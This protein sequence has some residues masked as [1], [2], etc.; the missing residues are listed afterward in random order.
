MEASSSNEQVSSAEPR[1][2]AHSSQPHVGKACPRPGFRSPGDLSY[3]EGLVYHPTKVTVMDYDGH[4][5]TEKELID[6]E[7]CIDLARRPST[8]WVNVTG[9]K[10]LRVIQRLGEI[11]DIHP[12]A[13]EDV[14]NTRHPPK[15]DDYGNS[16]FLIMRK[17]KSGDAGEITTEQVSIVLGENYILTF[18]E[19]ENDPF[20]GVRHRLRQGRFRIRNSGPDYLAYALL[21]AIMDAYFPIL[22]R[23]GER[24]EVLEDQVLR[25]PSQATAVKILDLKREV[26]HLRQLSWAIRELLTHLARMDDLLISKE[27]LVYLR[28]VQ[29]HALR[30]QDQ[31]ESYRE[32]CEGLYQAYVSNLTMRTN[33]VVR[34]LTIISTI[35]LPLNFIASLFGMNFAS[36][37]TSHWELGFHVALGLMTIIGLGMLY[38]FRRKKWV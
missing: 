12:L 13:L 31:L 14:L 10:D 5:L 32:L 15:I 3:R 25:E 20:E 7:E 29:D 2:P 18:H 37:P 19:T 33:D 35:F 17:L 38:W 26:I 21:D 28:D 22:E 23:Y 8:T 6:A 34:V 9:L 36:I 24:I 27:T 4:S 11:F 1:G 16:L 30:V